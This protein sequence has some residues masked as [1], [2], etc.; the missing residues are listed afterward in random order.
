M[1]SGRV[2]SGKGNAGAGNP[3]FAL[4]HVGEAFSVSYLTDDPCVSCLG[5]PDD[6]LRNETIG[7]SLATIIFPRFAIA[8]VCREIFSFPALADELN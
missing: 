4:R 1:V 7:V 2:F 3:E 6:L 8:G 5:N